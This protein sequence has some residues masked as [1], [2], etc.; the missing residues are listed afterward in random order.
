M[1][2]AIERLKKAIEK[3]NNNKIPKFWISCYLSGKCS[4]QDFCVD[5]DLSPKHDEILE[6]CK[7]CIDVI[8]NIYPAI[9]ISFNYENQGQIATEV[10]KYAKE[11]GLIVI[12]Y[13]GIPQDI[14]SMEYLFSKDS[15]F[16]IVECYYLK[17]Q[18]QRLEEY[19]EMADKNNQSIILSIPKSQ[20][21]DEFIKF[22]QEN[23]KDR[24]NK[25]TI[26]YDAEL[27]KSIPSSFVF[28]KIEQEN[29]IQLQTN[30]NIAYMYDL[31]PI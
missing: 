2:K 1:D 15:P 26:I 24:N 21:K 11:N 27:L 17:N 12:S 20:S 28:A 10:A 3:K 14:I 6:N 22:I 13:I 31:F 19:L 29:Q 23:T 18:R 7:K 25:I 9:I 16:D 4:N 30:S 5:C 8:K